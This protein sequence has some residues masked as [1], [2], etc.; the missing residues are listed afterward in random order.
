MC[1]PSCDLKESFSFLM[2]FKTMKGSEIHTAMM[3][4]DKPD[5]TFVPLKGLF[6]SKP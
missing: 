4:I 5:A 3:G 2:A 6:M 1:R